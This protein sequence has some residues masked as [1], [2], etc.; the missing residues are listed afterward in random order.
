MFKSFFLFI[1]LVS[2]S[3]TSDIKTIH[4][5]EVQN[6]ISSLPSVPNNDILNEIGMANSKNIGYS[7]KELLK[8]EY[9]K[10]QFAIEQINDDNLKKMAIENFNEGMKKLENNEE[11]TIFYFISSESNEQNIRTFMAYIDVLNSH[12]PNIKGKILLN[13]Y[14]ENLVDVINKSLNFTVSEFEK[15]S[16]KGII[17]VDSAGNYSYKVKSINGMT[18]NDKYQ[19]IFTYKKLDGTT[20]NIIINL[21]VDNYSTLKVVGETIVDSMVPYLKNLREKNISSSN[22]KFHVHPWAFK[23]LNLNVVPAYVL[24]YC[25]NENF[26]FRDCE[27]KFIAKGNITLDYFMKII[28]DK[29]NNYIKYYETLQ[30]GLNNEK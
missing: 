27:N 19:D 9:K 6:I 15:E 30:K 1:I 25:D 14:P 28:A 10:F 18:P 29:N 5:N 26:R 8:E 12:Y 7:K 11:I 3:Y 13:N 20:G 21:K 2:T 22:V 16:G 23:S 17:K 4:D 24:S